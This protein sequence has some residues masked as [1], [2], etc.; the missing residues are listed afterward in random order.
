MWK[1]DKKIKYAYETSDF[2]VLLLLYISLPQSKQMKE[3]LTAK[4]LN[5]VD[6]GSRKITCIY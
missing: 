5:I 2:S 4:N 3:L 1:S 6:G